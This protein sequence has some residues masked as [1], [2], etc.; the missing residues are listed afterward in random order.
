MKNFLWNIFSEYL[1]IIN[2]NDKS[3]IEILKTKDKKFGDYTSN[4]SLRLSKKINKNPLEIAENIK[5][6]LLKNYQNYFDN[7]TVTKPGFVNIFLSK[8][9]V[10]KS[11]MKF[12]KKNYKPDF[13][14]LKKEKI[15]YE[16]VSANPTGDLH[17]GHARNAI[18]GSIIVKILKY[19]GHDVYTE[20]Y[21][22]DGGNQMKILAESVYYYFAPLA[23]HEM[24]LKKDSVGYHGKE[25]VSFSKKLFDDGFILKGNTEEE[26]IDNLKKISGTYFLNEIKSLLK[27]IGLPKF[28]KW[29]SESQLLNEETNILF[30]KLKK[31]NNIYEFE[32]A[33]WIRVDKFG[34][35]KDRV[36]I[37]KDGTFTYMVADIANHMNKAKRGFDLLVNLWGKDHHG[38]EPRIQASMKALN[39]DVPLEVDYISMVQITDGS[40]IVKMSKRA[41]TSLR[42]K[43]ILKKIDMDVFIYFIVSKAKEQE[44]EIN[45]DIASQQDLSNPFYYTQYANARMSQIIEKYKMEFSEPKILTSFIKLGEEERERDLLNKMIE[46][47]DIILS[48]NKDREPSLILNYFKDLSK[49]FNSYYASCQVITND[50]ELS[51]ERINLIISL[52]NQFNIIFNLIGIKPIDKI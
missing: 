41:G 39:I 37:K 1:K 25:I 30:E 40:S 34:D 29:T 51:E 47:E 6:F 44:M 22:N 35:V 45:V 32:G 14:F 46:F 13:N 28:D 17:I 43:D 42:I 38:Y 12:N 50:F 5:L 26:R 11:A 2:S 52:K 21:I 16:Y 19:I 18:V 9:L 48:I 7:I 23:G 4:I 49:A 24:T 20:Y 8:D 31:E 10:V 3:I 33:T 15:N 27:K 36:L